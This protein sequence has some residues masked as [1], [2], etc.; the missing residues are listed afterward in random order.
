[1]FVLPQKL[2]LISRAAGRAGLKMTKLVIHELLMH[3]KAAVSNL[4]C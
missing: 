1:M 2:A 4:V 3:V